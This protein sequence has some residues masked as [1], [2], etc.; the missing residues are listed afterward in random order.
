VSLP[1]KKK[2]KG[3]L[4]KVSYALTNLAPSVSAQLTLVTFN[5]NL[6]F[7]IPAGTF[8][9]GS[10]CS[11]GDAG[12]INCAFHQLAPGS[13][14]L[15]SFTLRFTKA[16]TLTVGMQSEPNGLYTYDRNAA[17]DTASAS[18]RIYK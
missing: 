12:L 11:Q 1:T 16:G 7:K 15:G 13:T 8:G 6:P 4:V 10:P 3:D 2:H 14:V 17:N 9:S 18:K 5:L